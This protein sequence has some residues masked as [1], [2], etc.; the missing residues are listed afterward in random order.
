MLSLSLICYFGQSVLACMS[1]NFSLWTTHHITNEF[2]ARSTRT[3]ML[4]L[5][6]LRKCES[7][8]KTL[9]RTAV[10]TERHWLTVQSTKVCSIQWQRGEFSRCSVSF[11]SSNV[12]KLSDVSRV[13]CAVPHLMKVNLILLGHISWTSQTVIMRSKFSHS[14]QVLPRWSVKSLM[15]TRA[16]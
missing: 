5:L 4:C 14:F 15:L 6:S 1:N 10:H 11:L 7:T 8:L 12:T 16:T 9:W 2:L 13:R 3:F